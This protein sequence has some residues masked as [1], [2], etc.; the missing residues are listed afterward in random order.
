MTNPTYEQQI[1]INSDKRISCIM[2]I[3]GCGKTTTL[4]LKIMNNLNQNSGIITRTNSVVE[5]LMIQ[6]S[7]YNVYFERIGTS[8]HYIH[9]LDDGYY[10]SIANIDAFIDFQLRTYDIQWVVSNGGDFNKKK[11]QLAKII[12]EEK[13]SNF[14][15]K[16]SEKID[17]KVDS[18]Y[19]DEVQDMIPVELHIFI[20]FLKRNINIK[21]SVFGDTLQTLAEES[22]N[23]YPIITI[24]KN[25]NATQYDLSLCFRCPE[26]HINFNNALLGVVRKQGKYGDLPNMIAHKNDLEHKPFLFTHPGMNTNSNGYKIA[27]TL[28]YIIKNVIEYDKSISWGDITILVPKINDCVSIPIILEELKK[29]FGDH[30]HYFETKQNG[31]S[32]SIDFDKIKQT[33]CNCIVKSTKKPKKFNKNTNYCEQCK[34]HKEKNKACI[35]SIDG[36]KGK[37][38]KCV[39]ALNLADKSIPRENHIDKHE[40]L[41]DYSKLNVLTTRSTKYLFVGIN[42]LSPSRYLMKVI[43]FNT[44]LYYHPWNLIS[45]NSSPEVYKKIVEN[46]TIISNDPKL[47]AVTNPK[48]RV[49]QFTNRNTP[50]NNKLVV[51]D[52]SETIDINKVAKFEIEE[53]NYGSKCT[54]ENVHD[55]RLLGI[56]GNLLMF[57]ELFINNK[58]AHDFSNLIT[59]YE[60][61]KEDR[62]YE[63]ESEQIY[64]AIVDLNI[65]LVL[66]NSKLYPLERYHKD[67]KKILE[68]IKIMNIDKKYKKKYHTD[69]GILISTGT[70]K[71]FCHSDYIKLFK[72]MDMFFDES[73]P[74]EN[75]NSKK[76]FNFSILF[77]HL[78]NNIFRPVNKSYIN[79]FN[80]DISILH[81]N[82]K[83]STITLNECYLENPILFKY[84]ET[85]IDII[86]NLGFDTQEDEKVFKDGYDVSLTGRS[87]INYGDT[88]IE[89]KTSNSDSCNKNWIT[90]VLLYNILTNINK[91]E[92]YNHIY[93]NNILTGNKY[94]ITFEEINNIK[95]LFTILDDYKFIPELR[96]NFLKFLKLNYDDDFILDN[97]LQPKLNECYNKVFEH[98]NESE[99]KSDVTNLIEI[100]TSYNLDIY[101]PKEEMIKM[102]IDKAYCYV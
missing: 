58:L 45:T 4:V 16:N 82:C 40:E 21:C 22:T 30:F 69:I 52:I 2:G 97:I 42:E 29:K 92:H 99:L 64:S 8:N 10:I 14:Y 65:N 63:I 71:L 26:P 100:A 81:N 25:L 11:R 94:K 55:T 102:I 84:T 23:E 75:I 85:D 66:I 1:V 24:K 43:K 59:L 7:K 56:M 34:K 36:F 9:A 33:H 20:D 80:E 67:L 5:E 79:S 95:I 70:I 74:T 27:E 17:I 73:I 18:I 87:D 44:E 3:P 72:N 48:P 50:N 13:I 89:I 53:T 15:I 77:D 32:I 68:K 91:N 62:I 90:Q 86:S 51:T 49:I 28:K 76:Y 83:L 57:R 54:F 60:C 6:F 96:D 35:I 12:K 39:I 19:I 31:A 101:Y 78:E 88:L 98:K 38:S 46:M 41:T 93:I 61:Y 37:E 47:K